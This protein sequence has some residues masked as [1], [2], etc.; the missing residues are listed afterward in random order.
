MS[1]DLREAVVGSEGVRQNP[2]LVEGEGERA[3]GLRGRLLV[4]S[5]GI[6]LSGE[7]G[8]PAVSAV[9]QA[10]RYSG[11]ASSCVE[12][13]NSVVRMQQCRHRKMTQGL[14]DLKRL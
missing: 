6:S 11:R 14:L 1:E 5:V 2:A 13:V 9:R 4:W 8:K 7:A 10:I 12:G 3:R